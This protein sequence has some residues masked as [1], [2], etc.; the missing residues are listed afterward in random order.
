MRK[1]IAVSALAATAIVGVVAPAAFAAAGPFDFTPIAG[2]A[3]GQASTDWTEPYVLPEGYSQSL[4]SDETTLDVYPGIDDLHDMNTQNETGAQAGR[5]LYNTYEVGSNG[6][7]AVTDL[8]TGESAVIA[9]RED[10]N[11]L[12]GIVWTPWGSLLV[13]E[14]TT[15]GKVYE[16]FLDK[17]DPTTVDHI[18]E[19]SELGVLR[20]EGIGVAPD[21]S[22]FVI[23]EL[24]GGS[25]FKF[26][27]TRRG[28]L[29]EGRLHALKL[30]GLTDAAQKWNPATFSE[31]VG[32]FEWV[33]LDQAL[34]STDADAAADAVGATEFGRP[35]DVQVI[36]QTLYV[37][38]TSEDR[39]VAIDL[40]KLTV[41]SFVQAGLNVP[42]ENKANQV[43]GF[44][45]PD[46]LA[47]GPDGALWIAEDNDFSDIYVAGKDRDKDGAADSVELFASLKDEHAETTGIYFG[48]NPKELFVSVQ[49]PDKELADGIWK[50]TRD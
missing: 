18:E 6:A 1:K 27:P 33:A 7:V 44:N 31:K 29:S 41:A 28:D 43:T 3:Y 23:D 50:I 37:A 21:G 35:E 2:S 8:K 26:V 38:N 20:H 32:G 15:G 48:Q 42:V 46:N 12:D 14:E 45:N 40:T 24:N 16:V 47:V 39:V 10:W 9:Q 4:V 17:E 22:V 49:H 25:I 13:T 34:V 19:R 11:R 36:G 30:T 5:Y